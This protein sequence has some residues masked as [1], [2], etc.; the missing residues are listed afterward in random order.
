MR[1]EDVK[2]GD[3]V[4]PLPWS[5]EYDAVGEMGRRIRACHGLRKVTSVDRSDST[6]E[7]DC[8]VDGMGRVWWPVG[9][10]DPT[11]HAVATPRQKPTQLSISPT[12]QTLRNYLSNYTTAKLLLCAK[13]LL[14]HSVQ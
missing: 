9:C 11:P 5:G 7:L 6:V 3:V 2:V 1:I 12:S 10:C 8:S 4:V 13:I 14:L